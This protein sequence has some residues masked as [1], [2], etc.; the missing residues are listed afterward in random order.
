MDHLHKLKEYIPVSALE[1]EDILPVVI[2]VEGYMSNTKP[3]QSAANGKVEDRDHFNF[4]WGS[5]GLP[6]LDHALNGGITS[7]PAHYKARFIKRTD[8]RI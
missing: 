7:H 8:I 6:D 5:N 1:R 3:L 4:G 2:Y